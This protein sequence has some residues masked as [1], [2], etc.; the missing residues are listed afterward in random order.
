MKTK[1]TKASKRKPAGR[2]RALAVDAGSPA[3]CW[4]E[5]PALIEA[6]PAEYETTA[7]G[8]SRSLCAAKLLIDF[9]NDL[10]DI[11]MVE[12]TFRSDKLASSAYCKGIKLALKVVEH[13]EHRLANEKLSDGRQ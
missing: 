6:R 3:S 5:V 2:T 11:A 8:I 7:H 13:P 9:G 4:K 1:L 12:I 10:G